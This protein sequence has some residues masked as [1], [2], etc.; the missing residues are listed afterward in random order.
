[1]PKIRSCNDIDLVKKDQYIVPPTRKAKQPPPEPWELPDFEPLE[2][3]DWDYPGEPNLTPSVD[4]SSPFDVWSLF[5]SDELMDKIMEW[6][7]TFAARNPTPPEKQPQNKARNW[8]STDK[9]EL[10]AYFATLIHMGITKESGIIDYWGSIEAGTEHICKKYLGKNRFQQLDRY[11][12]MTNPD[13]EPHSTFDRIQ[14]GAEHIRLRCRE[15]FTP[16]T[17]LAVDESIQRFLGRSSEIV[18]IPSKPTPEGYKIW[19]LASHG[20]IL[21]W[22]WHAKGDGKGPVDLDE[23]FTKDEGFTKTQAVVLDLLTQQDP[24]TN[25]RLYPPGRYVVWLDNLFTGIKL[26]KRLRGLGIGAVGTVRTTR[27]KRE[28]LEDK[29]KTRKR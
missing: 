2:I 3:E 13:I 12:R 25:E 1:M 19:I 28:E 14:D 6:T 20:Y 8:T 16:G 7:N 22:L 24:V 9:P 17:H 21:D 29:E 23:S 11:I 4:L 27:T 10:Y 15:L 26:F 18:N 5:F